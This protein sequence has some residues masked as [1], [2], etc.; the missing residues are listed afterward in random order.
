MNLNSPG[1]TSLDEDIE[2][3]GLEHTRPDTK[4]VVY[5]PPYSQLKREPEPD[6]EEEDDDDDDNAGEEGSS[7]SLLRQNRTRQ[8]EPITE[9]R[10]PQIKNIVIEVRAYDHCLLMY[11]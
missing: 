8:L 1:S 2:L 4:D 10:W 5:P 6:E 9:K 3:I 11:E 7:E